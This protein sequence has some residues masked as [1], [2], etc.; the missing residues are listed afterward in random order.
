M[1]AQFLSEKQVSRLTGFA[2]QTLRNWRSLGL[3]PPYV[4]IHRSIRYPLADL[5]QFM[6]DHKVNTNPAC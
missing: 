4:R 1:D 2:L 6:E 5:L 3:G